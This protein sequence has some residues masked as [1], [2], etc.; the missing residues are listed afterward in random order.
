MAEVLRLP[1]GPILVKE[2]QLV[3]GVLWQPLN[4]ALDIQGYNHLDL[5]LEVVSLTG[6]IPSLTVELWTGM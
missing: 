5:L 2:S 4:Q 6:T 3:S 1:V